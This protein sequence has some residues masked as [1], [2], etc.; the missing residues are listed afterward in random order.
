MQPKIG[1]Q[2]YTLRDDLKADFAG[3]IRAIAR[4][5][6]EYIETT[7]FMGEHS[8]ATAQLLRETGLKIAGLGFDLNTLENEPQHVMTPAARGTDT[9][10]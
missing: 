3:T 8:P 6:Y 1:L 4:M 9:T 7:G 2:L 10:P 5:G